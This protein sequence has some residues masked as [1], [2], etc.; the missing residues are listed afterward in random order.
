VSDEL[1]V[2][3]GGSYAVATDEML[4][5]AAN[6]LRAADIAREIVGAI[7]MVDARL[8]I[9][10]LE[11]LGIPSGAAIAE[12]DLGLAHRAV[13]QL[14]DRAQQMSGLVRFAAESYGRG[15]A[16]TESLVRRVATDAAATLGFLFPAWATAVALTSPML[17]ILAGIGV[18]AFVLGKTHP[19]LLEQEWMS[20]RLND[21]IS[22]PAFV[23]AL[24]HSVMTVDEFS[25]GAS[26][27][28]PAMVSALSGA[29]LIGLAT[30]AGSIQQ[31]G[32]IAGL[33]KE[34][35]VRLVTR[36]PPVPV[37]AADS[38]QERIERIPQPTPEHPEQVR[39]ERYETPGEAPRFEVY[40]AG[41]VDFAISDTR[42]PFDTT[43]NVSNAAGR[44]AGSVAAVA[45]AMREAG[46]TSE[47]PVTFTGHSQGGGTAARL[48]QSGEFN[49]YGVLSVGGNTGQI[50][51]P[52]SV[53]AIIIEHTDDLVVAAGGLQDNRHALVVER[54]AYGGIPLPAATMVPAHH[55]TQYVETGRLMDQS[56]STELRGA[57][58]RMAA[59]GR[60]AATATVTSYYFERVSP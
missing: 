34:T 55:L 2:S 27:V 5:N 25:A 50:A 47:S 45:A 22:D 32:G 40:I 3:G 28:P 41:T 42:E 59:F 49:T 60:G 48:A 52:D 37:A 13:S 4:S 35:A 26:G 20:A 11:A 16:L 17:P 58:D 30:A 46:V 10:Q 53:P 7:H 1:V 8:T 33:V 9:G 56:D 15:E 39:I 18:A 51:I 6:L 57:A 44:E 31:A 23:L 21:L 43:S 29:G 14:A 19:Q 12:Q 38:I 54:Q 24:R 36:T